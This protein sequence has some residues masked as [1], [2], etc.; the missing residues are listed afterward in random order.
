MFAA[1]L[2]LTEE[3]WKCELEYFRGGRRLG[4]KADDQDSLLRQG[5]V[6][7]WGRG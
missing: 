1:L 4:G 6:W 7:M 5:K 2:F 3:D